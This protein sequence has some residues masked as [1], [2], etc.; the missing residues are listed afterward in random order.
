VHQPVCLTY[1]I[2][3]MVP[4]GPEARRVFSDA[5]GEQFEGFVKRPNIALVCHKKSVAFCCL[6]AALFA[7]GENADSG[8]ES[9]RVSWRWRARPILR[10]T[11]TDGGGLS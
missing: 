5:S 10:V 6:F 7:T 8:V 9:M 1:K 11:L 4:A 3:G 2:P